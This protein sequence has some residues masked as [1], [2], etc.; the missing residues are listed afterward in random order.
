MVS[1]VYAIIAV[2]N[3]FFMQHNKSLFWNRKLF[4]AILLC[5][6][7]LFFVQITSGYF[8]IRLTSL[9]SI[10]NSLI[11][12][13]DRIKHD[14]IYTGNSWDMRKY[15]ADPLAPYPNSPNPFPLYII[16]NDGYVIERSRP[17]IGYLDASNFAHLRTYKDASQTIVSPTNEK[18]RV[19]SRLI[20]NA[21][22]VIGVVGVAYYNPQPQLLPEIDAKLN[23]TLGYITSH[24]RYKN[25]Q[26]VLDNF[27][28]RNV[29]YDV[30]FEIVDTYNRTIL[31]NGRS[32]SYIDASYISQEF[33]HLGRRI[34]QDSKTG[35]KYLIHSSILYDNNHNPISLIVAG[36]SV[37]SVFSLL[38]EYV[39][40]ASFLSLILTV[41]FAVSVIFLFHKSSLH[42]D[43][44]E[45]EQIIPHKIWF[46]K[47]ESAIHIDEAK[48]I[49]PY[50][51]NQFYLVDALFS[52]TRK[53]WEH[54]ELLETFGET[55]DVVNARKMYDAMLAVNKKLNMKLFTYRNKTFL[56]TKE[57]RDKIFA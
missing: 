27:D 6:I 40:S 17:I 31:N 41:P 48:F 51:S 47:E 34:I 15:N 25:N 35:E 52:N 8:F 24:V 23:E 7:V 26:I 1:F 20:F 3:D 29:L 16:T 33:S 38:K 9:T 55:T 19:Y 13:I 30:S 44:Q 37:T 57:Y 12:F 10:D 45:K 21:T 42:V 5:L 18:W 2:Y 14:L 32:P 22:K 36:K 56:I 39:L 49:I 28:V 50:A 43:D 11:A 54:D 4:F 53:R 46:D